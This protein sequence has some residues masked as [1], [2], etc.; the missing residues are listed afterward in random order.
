MKNP[1]E[2]PDIQKPTR[3]PGAAKISDS[4]LKQPRKKSSNRWKNG[5]PLE[6]Q[7]RPLEDNLMD[8]CGNIGN[9][10]SRGPQQSY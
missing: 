9:L 3:Q 5:K 1:T 10:D 8:A 4:Q 6:R 7:Q 2:Q